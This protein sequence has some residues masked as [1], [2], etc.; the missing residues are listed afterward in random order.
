MICTLLNIAKHFQW[1]KPSRIA[2]TKIPITC[3]SCER[4]ERSTVIQDLR[5]QQQE[6][7]LCAKEDN[8]STQVDTSSEEEKFTATCTCKAIRLTF[9]HP[10]C[11]HGTDLN[12]CL[13]SV[14]RRY[15]ALWSYFRPEEVTF[16]GD[17]IEAYLW[18]DKHIEFR[19]C[20]ECGCMMY[21]WPTEETL[22][23]MGDKPMMGVNCRMM[24]REVVEKMT[25]HRSDGP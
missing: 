14:C 8:P 2:S 3:I 16:E 4:H 1:A 23:N 20:K 21:W 18:G 9:P 17:A 6:R 11:R 19:R 15:G 7:P 24:E 25:V 10:R 13:C 5:M 22:K 12:E